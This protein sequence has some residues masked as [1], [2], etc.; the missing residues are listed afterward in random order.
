V[1]SDLAQLAD[2]IVESLNAAEF[3][4]PFSAVRRAIPTLDIGTIGTDVLVQ[5]IPRSAEFESGS[6]SSVYADL[7]IDIGVQRKIAPGATGPIDELL[8]LV[9]AI[10]N[11]LHL[12]DFDDIG[13]E[14]NAACW[15][16]MSNDPIVAPEHLVKF[17]VFTSVLTVTYRTL[18]KK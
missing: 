1:S 15:R 3:S 16:T 5:V 18:R 14:G 4:V 2:A 8:G 7:V 12:L 9:Q 10:G 17:S 6:R 11:H 13:S